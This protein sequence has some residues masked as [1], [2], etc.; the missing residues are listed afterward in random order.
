MS[1]RLDQLRTLRRRLDHEIAIETRRAACEPRR[2]TPL[3]PVQRLVAAG[4]TIAEVRAWAH[5][6]RLIPLHQTRG[7]L[8]ADLVDQYLAALNAGEV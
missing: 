6:R 8:S 3:T 2:V 1:S 4:A 7:R 5:T